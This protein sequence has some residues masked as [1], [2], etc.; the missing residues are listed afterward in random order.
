MRYWWWLAGFAS[1]VLLTALLSA[2]DEYLVD[3]RRSW[4]T[5]GDR[6][7]RR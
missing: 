1:G 4:L 7:R 5:A 3:R 6:N 2:L